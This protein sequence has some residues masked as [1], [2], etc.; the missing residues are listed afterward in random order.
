MRPG[1]SATKKDISPSDYSIKQN[2]LLSPSEDSNKFKL[3][4]NNLSITLIDKSKLDYSQV[5]D[6]IQITEKQIQKMLQFAA[7]RE[8]ISRKVIEDQVSI[9]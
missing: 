5:I 2:P 7:E 9:N 4:K 6:A 1:I 3:T 8:P